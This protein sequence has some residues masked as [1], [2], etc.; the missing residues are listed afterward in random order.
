MPYVDDGLVP[1]GESPGLDATIGLVPSQER[2]LEE[3][4]VLGEHGAITLGDGTGLELL[5]PESRMWL[6]RSVANR[7]ANLRRFFPL[8]AGWY[9][10]RSYGA[11]QRPGPS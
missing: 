6:W 9:R 2:V 1:R 4:E 10:R 5:L 11:R 8:T 3:G 7:D